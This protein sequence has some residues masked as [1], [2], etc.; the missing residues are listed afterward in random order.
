VRPVVETTRNAAMSLSL[1]TTTAPTVPKQI[2]NTVGLLGL[3]S[4]TMDPLF[5]RQLSSHLPTMEVP[6]AQLMKI[7][8][9]HVASL[10][11]LKRLALV[12]STPL[13]ELGLLLRPPPDL[14]L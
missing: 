7:K 11:L 12:I 13:T 5:E 9:V 10:H 1:R 6:S 3:V 8:P 14:L 4:A 2:A